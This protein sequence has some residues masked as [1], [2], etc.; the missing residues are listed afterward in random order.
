[1]AFIVEINTVIDGL[2]SGG[3]SIAFDSPEEM[4]DFYIKVQSMALNQKEEDIPS[5]HER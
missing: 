5:A 4:W 3:T 1:M 2:R